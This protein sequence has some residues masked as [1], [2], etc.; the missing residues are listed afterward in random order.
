MSSAGQQLVAGRI[1]GERIATG[2]TTSDSAT[3][4]TTETVVATV[5]EVPTVTG[6]HYWVRAVITFAS[7]TADDVVQA[8]LRED[9]IGGTQLQQNFC[10]IV[11]TGFGWN[12]VVEGEYVAASTAAK[13]F[14]VTGDRVGGTGTCRLEAAADRPSFVY[15][16]YTEG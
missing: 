7:D 14:V 4:T 8:R 6:R 5:S 3:F 12:V 2:R 13:T 11:S 15:V 1:P 9:D 16:N 10:H